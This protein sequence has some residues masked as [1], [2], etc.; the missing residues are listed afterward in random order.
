LENVAI[1]ALD[2]FNRLM[3]SEEFKPHFMI[4]LNEIHEAKIKLNSILFQY[5]TTILVRDSLIN[6]EMYG[7]I[8]SGNPSNDS[9]DNHI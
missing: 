4:T 1:P 2:L 7:M 8:P 5:L 6:P 3:E 9:Q